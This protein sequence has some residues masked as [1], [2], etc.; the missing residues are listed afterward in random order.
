MAKEF[1]PPSEQSYLLP[2]IHCSLSCKWFSA[3][4]PETHGKNMQGV[5]KSVVTLKIVIQTQDLKQ[6][7]SCHALVLDSFFMF[8]YIKAACCKWIFNSSQHSS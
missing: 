7:K 4:F 1:R 6:D 5:N 3:T 8:G 2:T